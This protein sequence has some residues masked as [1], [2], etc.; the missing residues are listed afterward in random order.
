MSTVA[1]D[2]AA[3][4]ARTTRVQFFTGKGGMGKTT[5]ACATAVTHATV[6]RRTLIVS[7]DPASNLD[8][9][10]GT[11]LGETPRPVPGVDGLH[12]AN[13]D[14]EAAAAAYREQIVGPYRGA[15]PESAIRQMEESLSGAC[16][17][18][19]AAFDAF[20]DLLGDPAATA[21]YDQIVFD[22]APTGHT[23]RLL[24]L[25]GAWT[26]FIDQSTTGTSCLGPLSGLSDQRERYAEVVR[27][28]GDPTTTTLVL[29]AR[30]EI[31]ALEE[32]DRTR[33]ELFGAGMTRQV[34]ALNGLYRPTAGDDADPVA[35]AMA[36]AHQR[37][38]DQMPAELA[39]L[40]RA[41]IPLRGFAPIG[42]DA[43]RR[44]LTDDGSSAGAPENDDPASAPLVANGLGSLIDELEAAGRGVVMTMGKG[45]VGKTTIAAAIAAEL[46]RRGHRTH[47]TTTD[48]AAHVQRTVGEH[49]NENL[50]V[51]RID[52]AVE[53]QAHTDRVLA[54]AGAGLDADGLALLEEDLRSP[55]TEEIAVFSAFA[56][57]VAE[58]QDGFVVLDTAPTGHTLL[59]LDAA[60][61][62]HREVARSGG[63]VDDA[64]AALLPS[65]RDPDTT[66]VVLVTL[67]E[68]TPVHEAGRLA[69]DLRRAQIEPWAC[70]VNQSLA[71]VGSSD[72][73]LGARAR[74]EHRYLAEARALASRF[75]VVPWSA[76]E[77]TGDRLHALA[78][79]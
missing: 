4:T 77:P 31:S 66:R 69:E 40:Q 59:L 48:P 15:L 75:C 62:Y 55:C 11:D 72:P 25:P 42:T 64:V 2:S 30:P 51:S 67:P 24:A 68:A 38:V 47:L 61:A 74:R 65:L 8:E 6:G 13:I 16:T 44:V 29:V 58:G 28:L 22:T 7:T 45:G 79:V 53:T 5:L 70:V 73:V 20:A 26:T 27:A 14:P 32:A 23:L 34:L 41:T 21:E 71:A 63:T 39:T 46:A 76:H 35:T 18:E 60:Q 56:R 52:P 9:V 36:D 57:T 3:L 1:S 33:A 54:E 12:A 78:A 10:L 43:L 17:V 50:R 37:A 19:I 49:T